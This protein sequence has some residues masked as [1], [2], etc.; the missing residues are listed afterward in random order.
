MILW[1]SITVLLGLVSFVFLP[2]KPT[3]RWFRLSPIEKKIVENRTRDNTVVRDTTFKWTHVLE[4]ISEPRF[5]SYLVVSVC[6]NL[7]NGC[8]TVF[9]SQIISDMGFTV[10]YLVSPEGDI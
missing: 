6:I 9:Q 8:F 1:G 5:Y 3:S 4:A 10:C 2:D 7:L